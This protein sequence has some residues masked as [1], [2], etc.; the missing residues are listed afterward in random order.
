MSSPSGRPEAAGGGPPTHP[1]GPGRQAV[2]LC[3]VCG[4]VQAAL[5]EVSRET[6]PMAHK[7]GLFP[8]TL[9]VADPSSR[10]LLC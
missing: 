2:R 4:C 10:R 1:L 7:A 3:I 8:F 5:A 9:K 6:G